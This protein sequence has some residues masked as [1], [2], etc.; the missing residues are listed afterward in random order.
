M[1]LTPFLMF[2]HGHCAAATELYLRVFDDATLDYQV[3]HPEPQQH[4]V[5]RSQL[6]VHGQAIGLNDSPMP[7]AFDFTPSH[8]FF[9]DCDTAADVDR[10]AA[11]LGADGA[12]LMP[13][14]DYGFSERFAW[15]NDRF[16]VSW[17]LNFLGA[18]GSQD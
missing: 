10:L 15:V 8:S 11:E 17:Q 5:M 13:S 3:M 7:H 18:A 12:V 14:D 9:I 1:R 6:T 16:G 2:Q 4:L